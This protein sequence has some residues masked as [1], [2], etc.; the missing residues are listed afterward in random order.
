MPKHYNIRWTDDDLNEIK[1]VT[2]N[3]NAKV[4]RLEKKY[5]GNSD[6]IL[7][8]KLSYKDVVNLI[9]TRRD[10]NREIK[11]LQKFSQRGSEKLVKIPNSNNNRKMTDW[12]KKDMSR[13]ANKINKVR[14]ERKEQVLNREIK[15]KHKPLGY[16]R[17][18]LGM[19][20]ADENM[21]LPTNPFPHGMS[22][23]ESQLKME[24]L[25][26]ESQSVY[27]RKRDI[28]LRNNFLDAL[29]ENLPAH[30]IKDVTDHILNMD[31]SKFIDT[32][33]EHPDDFSLA[34]PPNKDDIK[35]YIKELRSNWLPKTKP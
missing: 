29:T 25:R 9:E 12:Q 5:S 14:A 16:T 7:P 3:F 28:L 23:K 18:E 2:R 10:L 11:S 17:G 19:G 34:Y 30:E 32:F 21:L 6:I 24:H 31:I 33:N 8:E 22:Q 4:S 13:R 15:R 20:T 26:R 1:R 27:W 35:N